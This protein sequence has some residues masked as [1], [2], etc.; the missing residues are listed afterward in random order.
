MNLISNAKDSYEANDVKLVKVELI[1]NSKNEATVFVSDN[2]SGIDQEAVNHI[3]DPFYTTKKVGHGTGLGLGIVMDLTKEMN[4]K[5][6]VDSTLGEGS[7][8]AVS[9]PL[10]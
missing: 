10:I 7:T 9:F 6:E 3:F 4:A 5:I 2:G 8:F 1:S